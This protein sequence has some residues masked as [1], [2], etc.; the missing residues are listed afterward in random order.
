M[1]FSPLKSTSPPDERSRASASDKGATGVDP[2][3]SLVIG[4]DTSVAAVYCGTRSGSSEELVVGNE[5]CCWKREPSHRLCL[6][7]VLGLQR[8]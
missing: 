5:G 6:E 8:R 2:L 1:S 3:S 7:L 4:V